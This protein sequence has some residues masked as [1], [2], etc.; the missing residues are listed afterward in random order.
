MIN[1]TSV[2]QLQIDKSTSEIVLSVVKVM[3]DVLIPQR[4]AR[5]KHV[6]HALFFFDINR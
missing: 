5:D 1:V 3:D 4:Q 6:S 2:I